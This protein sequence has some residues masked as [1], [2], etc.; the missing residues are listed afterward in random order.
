MKLNQIVV[1]CASSPG[2]GQAFLEAAKEVGKV[3]VEKQITLVYGGGRVGLMG[4]VADAVMEN[5]GHVIG[6]IPQFLNSKEIGHSGITTLIEV[7][8]MHERKA[9]MNAL[10]D[11]VIAMPG[12][13]GTMEELFEMTTWGQLGLHK[14]P[15]GILNV[16][17]FYDHFIAFIQHMVDSGL[18]KEENQKMILYSDNIEDLLEQ[19]EAYEAPPVP[20]WLN[21][22]RS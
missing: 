4:A 18:L 9:K 10:C 17:G 19:M 20:K 16:D 14:K 22:E 13:F 11:G 2:H 8:T 3:F 1:F 15:I 5:G 21:I 7:D 6:V 12:G